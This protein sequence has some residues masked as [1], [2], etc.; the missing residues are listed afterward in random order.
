MVN[1]NLLKFPSLKEMEE[2]T[3][4]RMAALP[5]TLYPAQSLEEEEEEPEEPEED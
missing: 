1:P 4:R 2:E 3:L 5:T